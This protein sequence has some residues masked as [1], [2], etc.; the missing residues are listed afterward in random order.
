MSALPKWLLIH[1]DTKYKDP[2]SAET[3]IALG[4]LIIPGTSF[5]IT[6]TIAESQ[7]LLFISLRT[8]LDA[9]CR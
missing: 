6:P 2:S 5:T 4:V 8:V 3:Q 9:G 7:A 1:S